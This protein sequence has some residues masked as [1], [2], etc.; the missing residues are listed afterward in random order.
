[1][2][3]LCWALESTLKSINSTKSISHPNHSTC[4]RKTFKWWSFTLKALSSLFQSM[5]TLCEEVST[6]VYG[7]S[8]LLWRASHES[9][10]AVPCL[11]PRT[12][13]PWFVY[14]AI[15][16]FFPYTFWHCDWL[17]PSIPPIAI[18]CVIRLVLYVHIPCPV[19]LVRPMLQLDMYM[20]CFSIY[21]R[22]G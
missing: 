10:R 20:A 12:T 8:N 9:W 16:L 17:C 15:I 7:R 21:V 11:L 13:S 4:S 1:M 2:L 5:I 19:G 3:G 6:T 22:V 18:A 14:H